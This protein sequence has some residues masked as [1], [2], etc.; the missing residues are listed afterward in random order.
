MM[1]KF[2]SFVLLVLM[3]AGMMSV[4]AM[5]AGTPTIE[6]SSVEA[7]PGE[8]VTVSVSLVNNPGI[9]CFELAVSYDTSKLEWT[10]VTSG[11]L[12]GNWDVAVGETVMWVNAENYT[13]DGEIF[14]LTFKVRDTASGS[15]EITL[16][17]EAG[18]VFDENEADVAFSVSAGGIAIREKGADMNG[19][20]DTNVLDLVTLMKHLVGLVDLEFSVADVTADNKVNVVDVIRLARYLAGDD[21]ELY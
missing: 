1:K 14:N 19:D 12:D 4:G 18:E 9:A 20:G 13:Q 16:S 8:T 7:A 6:V 21:V 2:I 17:Y 15:A 5:A 11:G 10:G 3:L